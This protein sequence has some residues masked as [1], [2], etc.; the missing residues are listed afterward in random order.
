MSCSLLIPSKWACK[1]ANKT[2]L[3]WAL[4]VIE[5]WKERSWFSTQLSPFVA[6]GCWPACKEKWIFLAE[7]CSN[8]RSSALIDPFLAASSKTLKNKWA[9]DGTASSSPEV[10]PL[11]QGW[12][13]LSGLGKGLAERL[14]RAPEGQKNLSSPALSV[15][16]LG[17]GIVVGGVAVSSSAELHP[18][19]PWVYSRDAQ[20]VG[21]DG[22][23]GPG[24]HSSDENSNSS[25]WWKQRL[26]AGKHLQGKPGQSWG[27]C[28]WTWL[29]HSLHR[30]V[31]LVLAGA[32]AKARRN[33]AEM[34]RAGFSWLINGPCGEKI[35]TILL[36]P[37]NRFLN[38]LLGF[39]HDKLHSHTSTPLCFIPGWA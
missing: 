10:V 2:Q 18:Q 32:A 38:I 8:Q 36:V 23:S 26:G 16:H 15:W 29:M 33:P 3:L 22:R 7:E 24:V 37:V 17:D 27:R 30:K 13:S 31:V 25:I 19:C 4:V 14:A 28:W 9:V 21:F 5:P 20:G 12:G 35:W 11:A 6:L 1:G 34:G 39:C